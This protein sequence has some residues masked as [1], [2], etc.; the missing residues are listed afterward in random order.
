M[1]SI[2]VKQLAHTG[3][4]PTQAGRY[5]RRPVTV[6]GPERRVAQWLVD[7]PDWTTPVL[8]VVMQAGTRAAI[9]VVAVALVVAGRRWGGLAV[10]GAG[11]GAWALAR[12]GKDVFDRPRPTPATLGRPVREV[13]AGPGF[14]SSHAAIAFALA[15][16]LVL[17]LR[18]GRPVAVA[19]LAVGVLTAVARVHFG[20]HWPL[21]VVGGAAAG[22]ASASV[23]A[24]AVRGRR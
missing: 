15:V 5:A 6:S 22:V 8:D 21:D 4:D 7:L 24:Y 14:P 20:V 3:A 11:F 19:L 10:L 1:A 13:V 2:D 17:L 16:T 12:F 18:P 23:A 9:V